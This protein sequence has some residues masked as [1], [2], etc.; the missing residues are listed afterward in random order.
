MRS[1]RQNMMPA[2]KETG[3]GILKYGIPLQ[4]DDIR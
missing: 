3:K 1:P 4:K 2:K